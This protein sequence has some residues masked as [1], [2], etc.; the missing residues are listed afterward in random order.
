MEVPL[1]RFTSTEKWNDP[2]FRA[3]SPTAK[4]FWSWLVDHCDNAGVIDPDIMLACFQIGDKVEEKHLTE[5]GDRVKRLPNGKLWLPKFIRFQFGELSADSRVHASIIKLLTAHNIQYPNDSISIGYVKATDSTKDMDK[6]KDKDSK[7]NRRA[8]LEEV[9]LYCA[10]A[11]VPETDA[12]WFWN[13]CE[14]NGW[15]N[16]GR[17]IQSWMHTIAAWKAAG[18]LPSQKNENN[19]GNHSKGSSQSAN[20]N[21]GTLNEGKSAMYRGVGK[22]V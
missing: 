14:A 3:L 16:G 21:T 2:W 10:K 17:P 13:K 4:L 6:D 5:L 1:K 19:K 8:T 22:V 20:R 12:I 18:Y 15:T 11:G 7:S 9:K